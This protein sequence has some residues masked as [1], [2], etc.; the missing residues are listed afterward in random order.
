M[1]SLTALLSN[2]FKEKFVV[3]SERILR[4]VTNDM[5]WPPS[6]DVSG[7]QHLRDEEADFLVDKGV[8][9]NS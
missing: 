5:S 7:K 6:S 3:S 9:L 2:T 8:Q 4:P 1:A